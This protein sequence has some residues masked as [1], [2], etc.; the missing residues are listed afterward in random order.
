MDTK[1]TLKLD[2]QVIEQAKKYAKT[3]NISLSRLVENYLK[4]LTGNKDKQAGV[5]PLVKDLT[6][7][8]KIDDRDY[9]A[10][11]TDYL[12]KKYR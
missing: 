2:K 3:H 4:A 12:E 6:G 10:D 1:L 9:R 8:V 5:G 7:V 11:Y